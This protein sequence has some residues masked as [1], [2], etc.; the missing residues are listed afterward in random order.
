VE[1]MWFAL[2][3]EV[4]LNLSLAQ[5]IT[6]ERADELIPGD[7]II[8]YA[9]FDEEKIPLVCCQQDFEKA[10]VLKDN[11]LQKMRRE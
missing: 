10:K 6:I 4:A 7:D 9:Y 2:N 1:N 5:K 11:M 3:E 8:I